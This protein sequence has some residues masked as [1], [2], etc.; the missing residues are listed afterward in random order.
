[1]DNRSDQ[2]RWELPK[3]P[4]LHSLSLCSH[5]PAPASPCP[6]PSSQSQSSS[7]NESYILFLPDSI[8]SR[9]PVSSLSNLPPAFTPG[10]APESSLYPELLCPSPDRSPLGAPHHPS[11]PPPG[12]HSGVSASG[13]HLPRF[14]PHDVPATPGCWRLHWSGFPTTGTWH[15]LF[16][17][18]GT[19]FP[20]SFTLCSGPSDTCQS[21]LSKEATNGVPQSRMTSMWTS[22]VPPGW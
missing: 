19:Q 11:A 14:F 12:V 10:L 8:P 18:P 6:V 9:L 21:R 17:L 7:P 2:G 20:C 1:M 22:R 13:P 3:V 5:P 16:P 4:P 15:R